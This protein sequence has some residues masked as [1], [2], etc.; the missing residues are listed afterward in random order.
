MRVFFLFSFFILAT[1]PTLRAEAPAVDWMKVDDNGMFQIGPITVGLLIQD[2]EFKRNS[3]ENALNSKLLEHPGT[4]ELETTIYNNQFTV[5]PEAA[6]VELEKRLTVHMPDSLNWR[7]KLT[8]TPPLQN[9]GRAAVAF[10]LPVPSFR[11]KTL[12]V[13]Q[14]EIQLPPDFEKFSLWSGNCQKVTLPLPAG[15]LTLSGKF[16]LLVQD[17]RQWNDNHFLL[18]FLMQPDRK[19]LETVVFEMDFQYSGLHLPAE[20]IRKRNATFTPVSLLKAANASTRDEIPEDGR[21]GWTDQGAANDLRNFDFSGTHTLRE[22]PFSLIGAGENNGKNCIIV[23]GAHW[24]QYPREAEIHLPD[25]HAAGIYFLHTSAWTAPEAGCYII[26][27]ADGTSR[28]ILLRNLREIFNWWTPGVSPEAI[29]GWTGRNASCD[30]LGLTLF[31]WRN[32]FPEKSIRAIRMEAAT[33]S[34]QTLLMLLG[35]TLTT[36]TPYLAADKKNIEVDDSNW[37]PVDGIDENAAVGSALDVSDLIPTPAGARGFVRVDGEEFRLENGDRIRF[38]GLNVEKDACFPDHAAADFHARR[39]RRLGINAIRFHRMDLTQPGVRS[40]F[41]PDRTKPQELDP[42]NLDRFDYFVAQLKKNGIYVVL[43]LRTSRSVSPIEEP[44]LANLPFARHEIFMPQLQK[45]QQDYITS[46]L[47]HRNPYTGLPLAEDPVLALLIVHNEDSLLY[48]PNRNAI[49]HP[50]ARRE[51]TRQFNQWLLDRYSNRAALLEHWGGTSLGADEDP[52]T[53]SVKLPNNPIG[54]HFSDAR[55]NDMRRFYFELQR[56]YYRKIQ[57]HL[58]ELNVRIPLT[59]SNHWTNDPLDFA[60]NAELDFTDRHAYWAHPTVVDGWAFDR[61]LFNPDSMLHHP[62]GGIIGNLAARRIGG[63]PFTV[64]EWNDGSTNEFRADAQVAVPAY[65]LLQGWSIF[66]YSYGT[67]GKDG[68]FRGPMCYSF[69]IGD[70]PVQLAL[71]PTM[72]RMFHRG[73]VETASSRMY[74]SISEANLNDPAFFPAQELLARTALY[75]KTGLVFGTEQSPHPIPAEGEITSRNGNLSWNYQQGLCR[76]NTSATCGFVGFPDGKT[77]RCGAVEF[78]IDNDFAAVILSS[79]DGK[80]LPESSHMLLT[81]VARGWNRGMR[82]N[83][84]RNR[85]TET[86]TLPR[87][88]QPVAG[89]IRFPYKHGKPD[90]FPLDFSGRRLSPA[91]P[92]IEDGILTLT[93]QRAVHYEIIGNPD[94]RSEK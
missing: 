54:K 59:G 53:G 61:V 64:T 68:R 18:L 57:A 37:L 56:N 94:T 69:G 31:G 40:L 29:I 10:H 52:A 12:Q 92:V 36:D 55:L 73:D 7:W 27:Y 50:L 34:P 4:L 72:A 6:P 41:P 16:Q 80:P 91:A 51:L 8:A 39:L 24:T 86:G 1:M 22:I 15:D 93:L 81:T 44:E 46:L 71:Y 21:G 76:I 17:L 9:I 62:S 87:L 28:R 11:G 47:T 67:G 32:P 33:E 43:D 45:L 66:Q 89:T 19:P 60:A 48:Q 38:L 42:E 78:Q 35:I 58:R 88:L 23:G 49:T 25:S 65:A 63:K 14:R 79:L 5:F 84:L 74:Q 90:I 82:F 83:A 77:I 26:Q 75:E 85:I 3:H 2:Q 13:D 30:N 70:D 20:E